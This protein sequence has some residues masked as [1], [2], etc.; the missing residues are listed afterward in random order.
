MFN[1]NWLNLVEILEIVYWNEDLQQM[2]TQGWSVLTFW[3]AW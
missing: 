2:P 3:Q 1:N